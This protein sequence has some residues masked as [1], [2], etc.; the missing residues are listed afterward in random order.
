MIR[1]SNEQDVPAAA[2]RRSHFIREYKKL[3]I[4]N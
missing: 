2:Q 3:K 1:E 4:V